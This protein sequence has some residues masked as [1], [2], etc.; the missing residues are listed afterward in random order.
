METETE[1]NKEGKVKRKQD[2][3]KEG[4]EAKWVESKFTYVYTHNEILLTHAKEWSNVF[5][6]TWMNLEIIILSEV[7]Q[8][9]TDIIW[10]H[11]CVEFKIWYKGTYL[12]DRNRLSNI[13]NKLI[14]K[15]ERWGVGIN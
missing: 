11:L 1:R 13:E 7:S 15:G 12:P 2:K 10:Y 3:R 5:A 4:K 6:A 9:K 14:T 8:R